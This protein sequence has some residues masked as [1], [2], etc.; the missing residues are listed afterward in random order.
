MTLM[1]QRSIDTE[2]NLREL[3]VRVEGDRELL[4]DIVEIFNEEFPKSYDLLLSALAANDFKQIQINA[5]TLKGMLASLSFIRASTTAMRIEQ[6]A[7]L[8]HH[9]GIEEEI[10]F[11]GS[12]TN[13]AQAY[14]SRACSEATS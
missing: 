4:S 6:M 7:R 11:L 9:E 1:Q 12:T 14:L 5:H 8:S 13:S 10:A 2:V 3:L